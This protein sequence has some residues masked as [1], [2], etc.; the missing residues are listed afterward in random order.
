MKRKS[1]LVIIAVGTFVMLACALRGRAQSSTENRVGGNMLWDLREFSYTPAI[2]GYEQ[3]LSARIAK[4]LSAFSPQVDN[5]G[6]VTI[7]MGSGAPNRLI[8]A[9]LDEPGFVVSDVT[10]DGYLRAAAAAAEWDHSAFRRA[11]CGAAGARAD[12]AGQ[13][14]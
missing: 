6:D 12:R 7:T 13:M 8:V 1:L 3:E 5:I 4:E 9:A 11:L 10:E 2:S 14:D